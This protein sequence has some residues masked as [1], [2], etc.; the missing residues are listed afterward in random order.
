MAAAYKNSTKKFEM[1]FFIR[2]IISKHSIYAICMNLYI[3]MV[4]TANEKQN[5]M[6]IDSCVL[7]E[8]R[9]QRRIFIAFLLV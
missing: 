3:H 1:T 4:N 8:S 9:T 2:K 7:C 5:S 6:N